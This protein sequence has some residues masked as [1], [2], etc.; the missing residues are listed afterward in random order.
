MGSYLIGVDIGTQGTKSILFDQE[1]RVVAEGFEPSNLISPKPGTI[2]QEADDI[3]G[4]VHRTI[5]RALEDSGIPASSIA[6]VGVD[7]QMAGIMGVKKDGSAATYYDSWLDTRCGKYM[8]LMRERAGGRVTEITGGP[9]TYTHGPKILWWK[10]EQPEA[11]REIYKFVL[12]HA[13][14]VMQMCGL[15]GDEAYFDYTC[16]QY[17]GFG[18][19]LH[20]VWS[21]EL[22]DTFGV[23]REK[24]ARIVSPFEI[25]GKVSAP[26]AALSGLREGTPVVAGLGDTAS[27]T[28]GSGMID[29]GMVQD[30]A[31][32]ASVLCSIV[33]EYRPDTGYETMTQVRSPIDGLWLSLAYINGGG[34]CVRW[35]RDN[36]TG[37]P[38]ASY[39]ELQAEAEK[40][41]PGSEG[42][43]FVPHFSGRVLPQN[44]Y[45]K[46]SFVGLDWKHTRGHLY[47]AVLEGVG[48][49]YAYY[50]SVLKKLFPRQEFERVYTIGGGAKSALFNQ[51]KADILGLPVTT[52]EMGETALVGCAV[53][54]GVACGLFTD[55]RAPLKKIMEEGLSYAPNMENHARYQPCART[56]L[57]LLPALEPIYKS[58]VYGID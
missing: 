15:S 17:S 25:A 39:D 14:V 40:I 3:A 4:S 55:Y 54:A 48:Y 18:D 12:P 47:R 21:D 57:N 37:V 41:A 8:K 28:F 29:K 2:W 56:Y 38:H 45:V 49:E 53:I 30:C 24:M 22:L 5:R 27:S 43:L 34:L 50:L 51:I 9:V 35:F 19:N 32:T 13:Y 20:K 46:G 31:G 10:H 1:M 6:A 33:D 26:F 44:P 16:L 42:V 7:G 36:F 23:S 11:Y 58:E 52:F